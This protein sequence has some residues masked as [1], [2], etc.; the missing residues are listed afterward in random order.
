[1]P[2]PDDAGLVHEYRPPDP[3]DPRLRL[4]GRLS[5]PAS[6]A[7][8][9]PP[10][11][12]DRVRE[13]VRLRHYSVRTEAAYAAWVRRYVLHHGKRHPNE[14]GAGHVA[15]FLSFL[16]T[17]EHVA[18]STQNQALS[19]LL[20]LYR[21]VLGR[22]L[23]GLPGVVR[24][25]RPRRVPTV[26]SRADVASILERLPGSSRLMAS[27]MYGSGVRVLEC[28]RLRV[29]DVDLQ[30]A[31]LTVRDGK[32]QKERHTLLPARL[33]EPLRAHFQKL[34]RLHERDLRRS[35]AGVPLPDDVH[36]REP[37][38]AK[39]WEWQWLF[40][41]ARPRPTLTTGDLRRHHLHPSVVQRA[42]KI[43]TAQAGIAKPATCHTLRHSFATHLLED[44]YNLREI[45]ELLG[46]ADVATTLL[47]AHVA[48]PGSRGL[49][50]PLD[51]LV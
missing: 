37:A 46:H 31:V 35:L 24:A 1:L 36:R 16:A 18:P 28:V 43:A 5:F 25:K 20:F 17:H 33:A 32:G 50:S 21:D 42:F 44:G 4:S 45:Q 2:V 13:A 30:N 19:A 34:R 41:A 23:G 8:A 40:P 10:R 51:R 22:E 26:L 39:A 29:R 14:L 6:A 47:Y 27:L 48:S 3:E 38:A 49:R 9:R 15:S 7:P 11:L 12:L